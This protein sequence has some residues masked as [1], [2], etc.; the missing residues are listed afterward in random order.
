MLS[1]RDPNHKVLTST[2]DHTVNMAEFN[3][4]YSGRMEVNELNLFFFLNVPHDNLAFALAPRD[5]VLTVRGEP[6]FKQLAHLSYLAIQLSFELM[7]RFT[8]ERVNQ[9]YDVVC[10]P[11]HDVLAVWTEFDLSDFRG[12]VPVI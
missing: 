11:E 4:R 7:F 8:L 1:V 2:N 3:S 5:H 12:V 10:S 6:R 9:K